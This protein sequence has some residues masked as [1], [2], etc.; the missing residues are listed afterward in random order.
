MT[1]PTIM[2]AIEQTQPQHN[3]HSALHKHDIVKMQHCNNELAHQKY[4]HCNSN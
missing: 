2:A 4:A 3:A 1:I